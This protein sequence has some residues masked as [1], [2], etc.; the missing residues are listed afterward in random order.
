MYIPEL[1]EVCLKAG[2]KV[3]HLTFS[4]IPTFPPCERSLVPKTLPAG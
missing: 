4:V 3:Q 2:V 1:L